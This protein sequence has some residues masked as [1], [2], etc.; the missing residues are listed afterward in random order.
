MWCSVT[1][2]FDKMWCFGCGSESC[3]GKSAGGKL[4]IPDDVRGN[5]DVEM[6]MEDAVIVVAQTAELKA[7]RVIL[8]NLSQRGFKGRSYRHTALKNEQFMVL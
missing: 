2:T 4:K 6:H 1:K 8:I 3:G 7:L 5:D